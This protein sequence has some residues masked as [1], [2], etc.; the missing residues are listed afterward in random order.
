MRA[1]VGGNSPDFD[2]LVQIAAEQVFRSLGAF[3]GRSELLTWI[4]SICYRVLLR[5][6]RWY[7]RWQLRFT[8]G[9]AEPVA[10]DDPLPSGALEVSERVHALRAALLRMTDKYRVVVVLHDLEELEIKAIAVIVGAGELTVRS[11]LRD[12]RKQL[13]RLLE[14]QAPFESSGGRHELSRS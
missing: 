2:D 4:Y 11:R 3:D 9:D 6:R 10:S 13:R 8:L 7:R 14:A 5:Q 12:G 1:L